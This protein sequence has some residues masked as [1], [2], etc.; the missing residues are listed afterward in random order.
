MRAK[1]YQVPGQQ[2]DPVTKVALLGDHVRVE[3]ARP[4]IILVVAVLQGQ[5]HGSGSREQ[6]GDEDPQATGE[7]GK[8]SGLLT[9]SGTASGF[10]G[11][12]HGAFCSLTDLS[13]PPLGPVPV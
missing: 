6:L 8:S 4:R 12:I 9:A 7:E 10:P 3:Q 2:S 5:S 13:E 11:R 1:R